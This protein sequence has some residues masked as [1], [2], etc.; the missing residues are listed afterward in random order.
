MTAMIVSSDNINKIVTKVMP[1]KNNG[2]HKY[3]SAMAKTFRD[4]E[5]N[6]VNRI[7]GFLAQTGHESG[8][9]S[10][11]EE[12]LNYSAER[13]K[14]VFPKYFPTDGLAHA[15]EYNKKAVA[16]RVYASR[17]GNGPESSGDGW[18]YRGRGLIQLT[19]KSNY[20][21]CSK[22]MMFDIVEEP[23]LVLIPEIA[24]LTSV[25][26]WNHR[27][28]NEACD[29][30]DIAKMTKLVQGGKLGLEERR[31]YYEKF[32]ALLSDLTGKDMT[33]I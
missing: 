26:Y 27:K 12:N 8:Q 29:A 25:W 24:V 32:K 16:N 17:L 3:S 21:A 20:A 33:S 22:D 23:E 28:I 15:Y 5:I 6:T 31:N 1:S 13:L 10:R 2:I 9:F 7:A 18:Q 30:D 4:N 11:I 14:V 19:G